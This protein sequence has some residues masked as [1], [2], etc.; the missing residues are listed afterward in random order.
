MARNKG[1]FRGITRE[2]NQQETIMRNHLTGQLLL[3]Q[4]PTKV[5]QHE[6]TMHHMNNG[7]YN[8]NAPTTQ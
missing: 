1:R 5:T 7:L 4:G 6:A 2:A 8:D 3:Q